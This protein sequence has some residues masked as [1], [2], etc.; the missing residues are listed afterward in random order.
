MKSIMIFLVALILLGLPLQA[1]DSKLQILEQKVDNL[2]KAWV[3]MKK[4][5]V[6]PAAVDKVHFHGYG[7]LHYSN[8]NKTGSTNLM[9]MHRLALGWSVKPVNWLKLSA[10]VDFEHAAS[11]VELEYAQADILFN[12]GFNLRA[13]T[14]LMPIGNVNETHE[15]V[16]YYSVERSYVQKLIIPTTW[17]EGGFGVFGSPADWFSYKA[18]IVGGLDASLFTAANGIR[19]GRGKAAEAK[20]SNLASV[21]RVEFRY[22]DNFQFGFSA[23]SGGSAQGNVN[24]GDAGVT[25]IESDIKLNLLEIFE[26]SGLFAS[27]NLSGTDKISAVTG[28]TMGKNQIGWMVEGAYHLGRQILPENQDLVIVTRLEKI[29]TQQ[30]VVSSLTANGANDRQLTTIGIAYLPIQQVAFKLDLENWA[31]Q[32]GGSWQQWNTGLAYVF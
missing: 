15:P 22:E 7:E 3:N 12:D 24:L 31:D 9:D 18:Y 17:Q 11:V 29:N 28:Q 13:G 16:N 26:F 10:E 1:A 2:V 5:E 20:G 30:E 8:T 27:L 19:G 4:P 14:L 32:A 25:I 6:A 21:G 23:Y